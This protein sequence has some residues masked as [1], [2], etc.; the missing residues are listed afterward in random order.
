M[1]QI[2]LNFIK[3]TIKFGIFDKKQNK[4]FQNYAKTLKLKKR[5]TVQNFE[6]LIK[7]E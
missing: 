2:L 5:K 6:Y 4:T 3:K 1:E 7:L